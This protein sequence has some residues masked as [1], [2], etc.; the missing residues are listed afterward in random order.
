MRMRLVK[1]FIS[2]TMVIALLGVTGCNFNINVTTKDETVESSKEIKDSNRHIISYSFLDAEECATSLLSYDDYYNNMN[3]KSL[4]FLTQKKGATKEEL[5]EHSAKQALSFSDE[6]KAIIDE[7]VAKLR[8][9]MDEQGM[10]FPADFEVEFAK[11]TMQEALGAAGYTHGKTVFLKETLFDE[12]Y[13]GELRETVI[14]EMYHCLTRCNPEFRKDMYSIIG[15]TILD[16]EFTI[17]NDIKEEI[18]A[19]PDVE[20]HDSYATFTINGEKKDCYLVFLSENMFENPGDTFFDTM[21]TGL[22][23]INDGTLYKC[24]DAED[25]YDVMGYNTSYCEDP[26][27]GSATNFSYALTYGMEGVEGEGY[28]SPEIIETIIKYLQGDASWNSKEI[29]EATTDEE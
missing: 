7:I 24:T 9:D 4:D 14:H 13:I 16:S 10:D 19:N 6:E 3:Q 12:E 28:Q 1:R 22:V 27:E 11:T 2:V 23:D 25:F 20:R 29:E 15:F 17:P 26:E 18:I 21:Y 8:K 5:K